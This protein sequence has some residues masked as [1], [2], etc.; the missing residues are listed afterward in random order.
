[1]VL[2]L[3]V[4]SGGLRLPILKF[5]F[6]VAVCDSVGFILANERRTLTWGVIS[7]G[8]YV[9]SPAV[10]ALFT[11]VLCCFMQLRCLHFIPKVVR[12]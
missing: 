2:D 8:G 4:R 1:M 6:E 9:R 11:A 3:G 12:Y 7:E 10:N 5:S